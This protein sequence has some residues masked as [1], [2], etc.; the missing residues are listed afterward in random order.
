MTNI[1][2]QWNIDGL[3]SHLNELKCLIRNF[4][5]LV[6]CIQETKLLPGR[7][8]QIRGYELYRQDF[9]GGAIAC[10]GVC[11]FVQ[12]SCF[13]EELQINTN[14]Q[15][16]AVKVK[17]PH[18]NHSVSICNIYNSNNAALTV[19]LK[20]PDLIN[21]KNQISSP[22]LILGDLNAHN[23]L[24]G[25]NRLSTTG[26]EVEKFLLSN[27][28]TNLLNTGSNTRYNLANLSES[29]I[30]LSFCSSS[31]FLDLKWA[32]TEDPYFSDH[33]PILITHEQPIPF[34]E[35][36]QLPIIWHYE[37]AKWDIFQSHINFEFIQ[38][39]FSPNTQEELDQILSFINDNITSAAK[40]AIPVKKLPSNRL[41][42]P[43]WDDEVKQA[44][45]NRRKCLRKA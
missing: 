11:I 18:Y 7:D 10:G 5:P 32:V 36:S 27:D 42:V 40:E 35:N 45:K 1:I 16:I 20:E 15:C 39:D 8:L 6:I 12:E 30:D 34:N 26:R 41:P 2:L 17:F 28:D 14:L 25:S 37:K 23:P 31:L 3:L 13:S 24:W 22:F 44:I 29:A 21:V 38:D 9:T 19:P 4:S 43:W 33:F